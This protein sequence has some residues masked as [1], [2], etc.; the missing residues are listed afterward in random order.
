MVKIKKYNRIVTI[1][2]IA[3]LAMLFSLLWTT[4]IFAHKSPD[5]CTGSG[6][7]IMLYSNVVQAHIGDT[8]SFSVDIYNGSGVGPIVCDASEIQASITTPDGQAHPITLSRTALLNKEKDFYQNVVTYVARSED[9]KPGNIL[10]ATAVD[11]GTIH[12]NDTNSSGGGN[13]GVN[14]EVLTVPPP[15]SP[16]PSIMSSPSPSPI[17]IPILVPTPTPTPNPPTSSSGGGTFLPTPTP[18]PLQIV[19][20]VITTPV[21]VLYV[22][23]FPKAGLPPKNDDS[24]SNM[25]TFYN[26]FYRIV[27]NFI[28]NDSVK[29]VQNTAQ[30]INSLKLTNSEFPIR[31]KIPEINIDAVIESVGFTS[32]GSMGVSKDRDNTAWFE[33]GPRPGDNG[34]A[35]ITG[36]FGWKDNLQAVFDDL[37]K[38]KKGSRLYVQDEKGTNIVFVVRELRTYNYNEDTSDVF[39]SSDGKAHLNLV[40]CN[41]DWDK[42]KESYSKRLVVFADKE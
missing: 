17:S 22:P 7:G 20:V 34:S 23:N 9:I 39:I 12:Q 15:P 30:D 2:S 11:T 8:I 14:I 36:H 21:P 1:F 32:D 18:T 28:V 6:L 13:Q 26:I 29:P 41:G 19:P 42:V 24:L 37:H 5:L 31:L 10:V 40:T 33:L 3:G 16:S 4:P 27:Q 38:L 35:V 25:V